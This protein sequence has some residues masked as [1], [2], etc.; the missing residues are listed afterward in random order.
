MGIMI[1]VETRS[2]SRRANR[3]ERIERPAWAITDHLA[4]GSNE[5]TGPPLGHLQHAT[6]M[7]DS[8]SFGSGPYH[9]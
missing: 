7:S 6:Q 1:V 9:L 5:A 2:R 8:L 4:I 3:K